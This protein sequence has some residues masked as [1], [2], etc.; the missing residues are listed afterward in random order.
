[1]KSGAY[2][3]EEELRKRYGYGLRP[4]EGATRT[5]GS[6]ETMETSWKMMEGDGRMSGGIERKAASR[7]YV[8]RCGSDQ[9]MPRN[10]NHLGSE[11]SR[12]LRSELVV[13]SPGPHLHQ[14]LFP[15]SCP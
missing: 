6:N 3:E 15:T 2:L 11:I 4:I 10:E 7:W 1:M 5:F 9:W 12:S 14:K 8:K 13:S